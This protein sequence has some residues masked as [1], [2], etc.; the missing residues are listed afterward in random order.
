MTADQ[1]ALFTHRTATHEPATDRLRLMTWN[2]QHAAPARTVRQ[3]DW[4]AS[5]EGADVAILT[6]VSGGGSGD[7][8]VQELSDAGYRAV[9]APW[10]GDDY[11]T[12]IASRHAGLV[13]APCPADFLPHRFPTATLSLADTP[14]TVA[15]LY[16]PSRGPKERRN[17]DK[18]AFQSAVS[19]ALPALTAR[20]GLVVAA[21][22]LNVVEPGH[23]P[24]HRVYGQWEYDFYTSFAAAGFT[25]AFRTLFP[26]AV[27][28]SWFGRRSGDGYR[29]DHAL[30]TAAHRTRILTCRYLHEPREN[31][32]SDHSALELVIDLRQKTA[33]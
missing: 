32:L 24:H 9:I 11:R 3:V 6:E 26:E 19:A 17:E 2:V 28:H 15:G 8:L 33:P 31:G 12:V 13:T 23:T 25:D 16:V 7:V 21:G 20:G 27:E 5:Q 14:I 1:A 29:F 30:V 22:D 10:G 4:L 18:R